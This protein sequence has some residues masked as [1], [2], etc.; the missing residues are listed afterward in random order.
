[1]GPSCLTGGARPAALGISGMVDF[2]RLLAAGDQG[3]AGTGP[4]DGGEGSRGRQ[5]GLQNHHQPAAGKHRKSSAVY[6]ARLCL[7]LMVCT[8]DATQSEVAGGLRGLGMVVDEEHACGPHDVF[9]AD[10]AA[11]LP[12]G[13]VLLVE[14]DGPSHFSRNNWAPIG[15]RH[16]NKA[17]WRAQGHMVVDVAFFEWRAVRSSPERS[18]EFL[19]KKLAPF[20]GRTSV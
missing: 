18:A 6:T 10:I 2:G 14:V 5:A 7:S 3:C 17:V 8:F 15:F 20:M 4:R 9:K 16:A 19:R 13:E 1:M 12:T 11:R